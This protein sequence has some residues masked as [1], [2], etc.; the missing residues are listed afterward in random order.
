MRIKLFK[1]KKKK[2]KALMCP[3]CN[4]VYFSGPAKADYENELNEYLNGEV[5]CSNC[6]WIYELEQL[7]EPDTYIGFN[8]KTLNEYKKWYEEKI[9]ENPNY[10]YLEEH[11]PE[12]TPHMCPICGKY[13]FEDDGSFDICIYCGWEDDNLQTADPNYAGGANELSLNEYKKQYE[14][15][16]KNNP[17]Y[18]WE[19]EFK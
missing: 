10:N 13:E 19:D 12:P 14:E 5:F 9:K 8:D 18:V 6:G 15:K 4:S 2:V 3:V 7:D 17:N 11:K 16:I 1:E